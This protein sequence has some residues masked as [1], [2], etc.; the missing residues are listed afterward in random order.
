MRYESKWISTA[1]TSEYDSGKGYRAKQ[2]LGMVLF[3]LLT[4]SKILS[5]VLLSKIERYYSVP[6][7][8][9]LRAKSVGTHVIVD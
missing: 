9:I 7:R 1:K 3:I 5:S 6:P 8:H 4:D 2:T